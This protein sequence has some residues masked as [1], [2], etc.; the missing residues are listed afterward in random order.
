ME[1]KQTI[2][3]CQRMLDYL[4]QQ[5]K[6][7]KSILI[8]WANI[9]SGSTHLNGLEVMRKTLEKH[10]LRLNG[11]IQSH[12]SES[13]EVV[14]DKGEVSFQ[15]TGNILTIK[16]RWT[17]KHKILLCGHMDTVFAFD[18]SFQTVKELSENCLN[19]PGVADMKG[20]L[21]VILYALLA[22]EQSPFA[23]NIG[24]QVVINADEEIGS[25]G[26]RQFLEKIAQEASL[27]LVYE[28]S[29]TPEGM[30]AGA[31]KGSGKFSVIVE[32]LAA[33]AGRDFYQGRNAISLLAALV[34]DIEK[35]NDPTTSLTINIGLISG[36]R[37][38]NVVPDKAVAKLDV[39]FNNENEQ[40]FFLTSINELI[41]KY[42]KKE[43]YKVSLHGN[44]SRPL[45]PLTSATLK[46][47]DLL[48][49]MG[50]KIDIEVDWQPSGGCCDGNN[51]S[52]QNL[53]VIDTLG[54]RG[55]C[56]HSDKEFMLVDSLLERSQLSALLLLALAKG[57]IKDFSL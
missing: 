21:V 46:L 37:A 24:W 57:N 30:F 17:S 44:F 8:E 15:K 51:L 11:E 39:R 47:F 10:F 6:E 33:H 1:E 40:K 34:C 54:V 22:F 26:S 16:K 13:F 20:G 9:N 29:M 56:I 32:G 31:R 55:G 2:D 42:S 48:K 45:K 28:P 53:A 41:D 19:G 12:D 38:L 18:S 25:L 3:D 35:L 27:A 52:A 49:E 4:N 50:Q 23:E 5:S 7:M 36:G 14:D 43:G